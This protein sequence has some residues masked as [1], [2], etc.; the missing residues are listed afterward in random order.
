MV[1]HKLERATKAFGDCRIIEAQAPQARLN[2]VTTPDGEV[3]GLVVSKGIV[4]EA[5]GREAQRG[6]VTV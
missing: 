2:P 3:I 6:D 4:L 5:G 1:G